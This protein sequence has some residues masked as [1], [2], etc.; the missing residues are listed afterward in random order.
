MISTCQNQKWQLLLRKTAS[1]PHRFIVVVPF[2]RAQRPFLLTFLKNLILKIMFFYNYDRFGILLGSM[3]G[4][5]F[6]RSTLTGMVSSQNRAPLSHFGLF[7]LFCIFM[8][9]EINFHLK[10]HFDDTYGRFAPLLGCM[11]S[12]F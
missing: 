6:I 1:P 10:T 5:N 2:L 3:L 12:Y 4:I 9:Y 8:I 7:C 11:L